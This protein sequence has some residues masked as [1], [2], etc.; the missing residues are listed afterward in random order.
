MSLMMLSPSRSTVQNSWLPSSSQKLELIAKNCRQ[1]QHDN[2]RIG[3]VLFLWPAALLQRTQR[4]GNHYLC[5]STSHPIVASCSPFEVCPC[6]TWHCV[7]YIQV[8][9]SRRVNKRCVHHRVQNCNGQARQ[10]L[11]GERTDY[12]HTY[13]TTRTLATQCTRWG[14]LRHAPDYTLFLF[15]SE[16]R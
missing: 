9:P 14:S 12:R 6:Q 1:R 4:P 8:S 16:F 7:P 2:H 3:I 5:K 15:G 13:I 11:P 10:N